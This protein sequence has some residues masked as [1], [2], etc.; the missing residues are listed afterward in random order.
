VSDIDELLTQR[1]GPYVIADVA[2]EQRRGWAA[3]VLGPR[4]TLWLDESD[5]A[6][7]DLRRALKDDGPPA[8]VA[9]VDGVERTDSFD[10]VI[11]ALREAAE[12]GAVL[13][14]SVPNTTLGTGLGSALALG[15]QEARRLANELDGE[16]V[17]QHL[18]EAAVIGAG[19]D[20]PLTGTIVGDEPAEPDDACAWLVVAGLDATAAD[21]HL[22]FAARPVHRAYLNGL[23][24]ANEELLRAN[25]RLARANLGRHDA[26]AAAVVARMEADTDA[27]RAEADAARGELA[28]LEDR[29]ALEVEVAAN[30]DRHF[31]AARAGLQRPEHRAV[32]ALISRVRRVPG[33][34]FALRLLKRLLKR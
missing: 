15:L 33:A 2:C 4:E 5:D 27:A 3:E 25:A 11:G 17:E 26:G 12:R 19:A 23:E 8:A 7:A 22:Q 34:R 13:V 18:A 29:L 1:N 24:R 31:Q 30:N 28:R 21:T 10:A 9:W 32:E 16:L 14:V 20:R 6:L